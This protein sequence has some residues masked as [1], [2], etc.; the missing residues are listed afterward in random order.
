MTI[1][2]SC[3]SACNVGGYKVRYETDGNGT[4]QGK[5]VQTLNAGEET[6]EVTA[7]PDEGYQFVKWSDE[8]RN[9]T[10]SDKLKYNDLIFTAY[11]EKCKYSV[12]YSSS[13]DGKIEG[14][15]EQTVEYGRDAA[16][17]TAVPLSGCR[18]IKWSDGSTDPVRRDTN[19][20]DNITVTAEFERE[21][22]DKYTVTY[23]TDGNGTIK[24]QA[25]QQVLV[26]ADT[27]EVIAVPNKDCVFVKWSDGVTTVGR[28]DYSITE[29]KTV[30]AQFRCLRATYKLDYKL[31]KTE[32]DITEYTFTDA[33]FETVDFPVPV[34]E[35]FTFGGWYLGDN[36]VTDE[37]GTMV[38]G[39]ELLKTGEREI[40]AKWTAN[41][42]YT[43]KVLM[44]YATEI[45]ATL[46]SVKGNGNLDVYYQMSDFDIEICKTVTRQMRSYLNDM[47]D[48]LVTF[49]ID[50]YFT[51]V[52]VRADSFYK[53]Q[54]NN[55]IFAENIP[56]IVNL[57]IHG[58]YQSIL[59]VFCMNDYAYEF[60]IA[61]GLG[62]EKYGTVYLESVYDENLLNNDPLEDILDIN[63][64]RWNSIIEPF[65]HELIHT[66]ELRIGAYSYHS[67]VSE[68]GRNGNNDL[69]LSVEKL[70]LLNQA[71]VEAGQVGI[72]YEFWKGELE[73]KPAD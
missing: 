59:T 2:L 62:G 11:F 71:L 73:L 35:H 9:A 42:N 53:G 8:S 51:T 20:K 64:W 36:Q 6:S 15:T 60:R 32:S 72:P 28:Q 16:A 45:D 31:G 50:E 67:V 58:E 43:Y 17:V 37:N 1:V 38:V 56:E 66:I 70:Y 29:S 65:I 19:I 10:R 4:I 22:Y 57:G 21:C 52:P 26:G 48:G 25:S 14:I 40:Y 3:F 68:Y 30:T 12:K 27:E 49:E 47:L 46:P 23:L 44:V 7:I 33:G 13:G 18:F 63:Y 41:E 55:Y 61:S 39:K 69:D 54:A 34:R 24:G 5:A